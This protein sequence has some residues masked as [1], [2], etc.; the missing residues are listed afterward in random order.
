MFS[1]KVLLIFFLFTSHKIQAQNNLS[2]LVIL[3]IAQ[4]GGSPQIGCDKS[5]CKSLWEN[6]LFESV[7]SIGLID[8]IENRFFLIDASPDITKQYQI[9][10]AHV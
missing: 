3:G 8:N 5:C 7:T 10:R 1:K 2:S 9:G 6:N 4:D